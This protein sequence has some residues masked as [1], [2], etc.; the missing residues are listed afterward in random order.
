MADWPAQWAVTILES[1]I[2]TAPQG[3]A[4]LKN[5]T[6]PHYQLVWCVWGGMQDPFTY[7][8]TSLMSR[9]NVVCDQ[10]CLLS[11]G[12]WWSWIFQNSCPHLIMFSPLWWEQD[13]EK[14]FGTY[15]HTIWTMLLLNTVCRS[16]WKFFFYSGQILS[17][18]F[19]V[20]IHNIFIMILKWSNTVSF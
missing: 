7:R 8:F 15:W 16:F 12:R 4:V 9:E 5:I 14:R 3:P 20:N 6:Y 19:Q 13:N 2:H 1:L 17:T 11:A 18:G 10:R